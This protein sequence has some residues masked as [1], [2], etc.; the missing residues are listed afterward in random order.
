MPD[1]GAVYAIESGSSYRYLKRKLGL[2]GRETNTGEVALAEKL[3]ATEK[4]TTHELDLDL[5]PLTRCTCRELERKARKDLAAAVDRFW[6]EE[7]PIGRAVAE[8]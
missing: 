5:N 6:V 8:G 2:A 7:G 3:F 4:L 1:H